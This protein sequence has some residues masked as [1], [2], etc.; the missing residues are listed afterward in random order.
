VASLR[1]NLSG[2]QQQMGGAVRLKLRY[3]VLYSWQKQN[4]QKGL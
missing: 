2:T 4:K 3:S 1:G